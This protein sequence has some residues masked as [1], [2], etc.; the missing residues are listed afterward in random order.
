MQKRQ[1]FGT[2]GIRG[3][4]NQ[5]PITPET[6]MQVAMAAATILSQGDHRH[7]VIIGKDTRLS[8]YMVE[9]SLAAGFVAMGIDVVTLGPLPTPAVAMLTRSLRADFGVMISASHNPYQDNGIK[10]F[11]PDG[12]KLSDR[13]ELAIE[14]MLSANDS[15]FVSPKKIGKISHLNDAQG[16]YIEFVKAT[17][18]RSQRLDGLKIVV[19]CAHGAAYKVAPRVLWELGADV[20]EI[21][22]QPN[23]LNIN[24]NCGATSLATLQEAVLNHQA[25][26]GIALDG[27]ADR[28]MMVDEQGQIIDGDGLLA[29]IATS[30][31]RA[32]RLTNN[33]VIAT[34]MSNLGFERYLH[35]Q[36][37]ELV[38]AAVGDRYVVEAMLETGSLLGGEQSG[39]IIMSDYGAAGDGLIASL[40][41]LN[42]MVN[43]R[44]PLSTIRK[45]YTPVPQMI[46]N[47]RVADKGLL[48]QS[49]VQE[50]IGQ[51]EQDFSDASGR[52]IVRASGTEPLIRLMGEADDKSFLEARLEALAEV[53]VAQQG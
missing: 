32:G 45:L 13:K 16:R 6:M 29:I 42:E 36:G 52:L 24:D 5:Y 27:D 23:G 3:K 12:L 44:Q 15:H 51:A 39:H 31:Q 34:Q 10:F 38:R 8:C 35:G 4:A 1:L 11:G 47:V 30:W 19:D 49:W 48:A 46:K 41:I 53:I 33:K 2:D 7:T 20:V 9:A 26:A 17:F 40:Q 37:I 14:A 21:G 18:P 43:S 22:V 25:H 28:L 50:A